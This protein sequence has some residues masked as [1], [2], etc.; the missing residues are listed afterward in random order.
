MNKDKWN[1]FC[2]LLSDN[3]KT[4]ISENAFEQKVIQAL[5]VLNWKQFSGNLD[6]RPSFQIGA[7]NKIT[8]DFIVKSP[9]GQRLY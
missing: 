4:E 7:A 3:I 2:F 8:P 1:E 9:E 6:V 5:M